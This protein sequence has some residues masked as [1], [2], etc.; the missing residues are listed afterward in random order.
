[1]AF[2]RL[3][4]SVQTLYAELLDQVVLAQAEEAALEA[5]HGSFVVKTVKGGR[6]WYMQ[7]SEGGRKTQRYLGKETPAL[8]AW[9]ERAKDSREQTAAD[10]EQRTSLCR[11]LAAGG[12]AGEPTQVLRLLE[13]LAQAGVFRRGGV[14][15]GTQAFR[16]YGN[17]LG[18]KFEAQALRTQDVDI[19]QDRT[20]GIAFAEDLGTVAVGEILTSSSLKLVPVPE[21]DPRL[22]S[23]SYKARGQD[24]RVDFL[25]PLT[26]RETGKPVYLPA[27]GVA[28][29]ALRHLDY[30]IEETAQ[31][32][33]LG[34]SGILVNVPD[35][36]RFALHK[37]LIAGRRSV[38]EQAKSAKDLRQAEAL[39][40]VLA[41]DRPDDVRMA[42]AALKGRPGEKAVLR[43]LETVA[44]PG[45]APRQ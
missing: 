9:I 44:P 6:Y 10:R 45:Y 3:P 19:A 11:M 23:T 16:A 26:G 36:A 12:A 38:S 7:V 25:T 31:A 24:L 5:P 14:L 13:L 29:H 33:I 18:V 28:A 21:L 4:G 35:P 30:L 27:L 32:V 15:V 8:L 37:L 20:I 34:G 42:L 17:M 39:L 22:P 40:A 1:M 2:Q 43:A 41:E